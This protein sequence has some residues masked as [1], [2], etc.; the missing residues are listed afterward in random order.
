MLTMV[1]R[2]H[3][4]PA[5]SAAPPHRSTHSRS[6]RHTATAAPTSSPEEKFSAKARRT[7]SKAGSQVPWSGGGRARD[8]SGHRD[9]LAGSPKRAPD[10]AAGLVAVGGALDGGDVDLDHR[11]H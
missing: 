4:R 7:G 9:L 11:H 3:G 10:R 1:S 2:C 5:A 6:P 8:G